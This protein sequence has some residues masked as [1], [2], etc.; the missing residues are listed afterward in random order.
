[1][2]GGTDTGCR[3]DTEQQLRL[4]R[5]DLPTVDRKILSVIHLAKRSKLVLRTIPREI[6]SYCI[7]CGKARISFLQIYLNVHGEA[8][9][10]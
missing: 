5:L 3:A 1:M 7:A 4:F 8:L 10:M 6:P 2:V 9:F